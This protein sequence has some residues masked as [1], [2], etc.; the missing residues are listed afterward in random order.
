L[1]SNQPARKSLRIG[2]ISN[3]NS[4]RN[5]AE[6]AA[7]QRI[8]ADRPDILHVIT[9][10]VDDISPALGH[11]SAQGVDV[12]AI[13]GGDGTTSTI[14]TALFNDRPFA[15]LPSVILLPGGTTNMN[16]GDVGLRG[17]LSTAVH[18]MTQWLECG[19]DSSYVQRLSRHILRVQGST[20]GLTRYGMALGAGSVIRGIEY[21]HDKVHTKGI[22]DDLGPGLVMLRTI[23]GIARKD[24]YFSAP[25]TMRIEIDA[26]PDPETREVI[27]FMLS[28]LERLFLGVHPFW[29]SESAPLY[30]TW[31]Q[32]PARRVLRAFPS[33]MR[34]RRNVHVKPENGYFSHNAREVRVWMD[35]VFALDGEMYHAGRETGPVVVSDAGEL[36]FLRIDG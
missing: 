8:V 12:L 18:R 19:C 10:S 14:F 16:V 6:L 13:N 21:F 5:Q 31:V 26:V 29:G 23:W 11:F 2:L 20:D 17:K 34:G 27:L 36:Q 9:R 7:I 32:T 15:S 35:G 33:L 25:T 30:C 24:A 3:P 1:N 22:R 4:R 28:S